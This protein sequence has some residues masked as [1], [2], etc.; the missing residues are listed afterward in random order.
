MLGK[1]LRLFPPGHPRDIVWKARHLYPLAFAE[2]DAPVCTPLVEA[3]ASQSCFA[4][5]LH[6]YLRPADLSDLEAALSA[7]MLD[8]LG[9]ESDEEGEEDEEESEPEDEVYYDEQDESY[10]DG[11]DDWGDGYYNGTEFFSD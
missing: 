4:C 10:E 7:P 1:I 6:N 8:L 2:T 11:E 9:R 3:R 5:R